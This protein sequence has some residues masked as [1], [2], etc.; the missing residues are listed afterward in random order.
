MRFKSQIVDGFQVFGVTGQ[1]TA[2]F[3]ITATTEAT[4]GLLW[5]AVE[6]VDKATGKRGYISNFKVFES[7]VPKPAAKQVH[8]TNQ[9]PIQSFVW[10]EFTLDPAQDYDFIFHPFRGT[11]A[12]PDL[13]SKPIS[14]SIRTEPQ[15]VAGVE[16]DVFFNRGVAS[17]QA[18]AD[19]FDN[20][21]PDK[22]QP[23]ARQQAA[24]D[25]LARGLDKAILAFIAAAKKGETLLGCFYEFHY[26]PIVQ[27]FK[28]AIDRGVDVKLVVD[29]KDN[30]TTDKNG[31]VSPA[32]PRDV[33][34]ATMQQ[35]KLP[36]AN[37]TLRTARKDNLQHNKFMVLVRDGKPCEVWTGSTN[38]SE[39]GVFGQTNVGHWVRDPALAAVY[40]AYWKLLQTDPG[41]DRAAND[42]FYKHV[43]Q[44]TP[45]PAKFEDIAAGV[46]PVFSPQSKITALDLY[47]ALVAEA[48]KLGCITLA[49]G[50]TQQIRDVLAKD[51]AESALKFLLL[52][53]RDVTGGKTAKV[54]LDVK[55]NVYEAWGSFLQNPVYQWL[56]ETNTFKLGLNDHVGYIHSKFLLHDPLG[57]D[58]IV[59]TG[60]ANFSKD[61]TQAGNDENMIIIRGSTR[62]ADIY[63]TEFNRLFFHY[64]YR[65]VVES[66]G[67]KA[68]DASSLFL[69]EDTSWLDKY[70]PGTLQTKR[71]DTFRNMVIKA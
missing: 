36:K 30:S 18:Y 41:G 47:A 43:E 3:G 55:E 21:S 7:V 28:D 17:S 42:T 11:P 9:H 56:A 53:K 44:L 59:V 39:G 5:F 8:P 58:P 4:K 63:F 54:S 20:Q 65:S 13:T 62:V 32:F 33:N 69:S 25:W 1:H 49:F 35:A 70:K 46:T 45:V 68:E 24:F 16:H 57:A 12:K 67:T 23:P 40:Q 66:H 64:Y 26:L 71:V 19:E 37:V 52:E 10:D 14:I 22:L 48:A 27:A 61:S 60:S 2:S 34:A 38:I 29:A 31:K 50:V 6:R 51:K 15:L